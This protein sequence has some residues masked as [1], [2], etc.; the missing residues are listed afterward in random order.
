MIHLIRYMKRT[1]AGGFAD[2][3]KQEK[4]E[5]GKIDTKESTEQ[6]QAETKRRK[7]SSL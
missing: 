3:L 7:F 5:E 4:A 1:P 2:G 6:I